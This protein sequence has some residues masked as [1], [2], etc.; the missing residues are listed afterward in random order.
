VQFESDGQLTLSKT[1]EAATELKCLAR[2]RE[3]GAREAQQHTHYVEGWRKTVGAANG[4]ER[5]RIEVWFGPV[6]ALAAD[7]NYREILSASELLA[8]DQIKSPPLR[9]RK[10]AGR[11]LLRTALSHV[12]H[13]R[14]TPREWRIHPDAKGRPVIAKSMPRINFS[15]SYA[16]AVAV[17]A[18]SQKLPVGI[19]VETV[20]DTAEDMIAAF[21]C[22]CEQGLLDTGPASQNSREF[23]RLWT[24]KEAYT[25]LV[26][27]GHGIEFDSIGFNLDSLHLLHG[28]SAQVKD[29]KVHFETMWV[30]SGRALNHVAIAIDFSSSARASADLQ[31]MSIASTDESAPAIHVPNVNILAPA[32]LQ[33]ADRR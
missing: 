11:M 3:N 25:K 29:R 20:E 5:D 4:P 6:Q 30:T 2:T 13:G 28:T 27:L 7:S 26:G 9:N 19:D 24:L 17:V 22:S 23:V 8:L 10:L 1:D 21:C 12:V 15:I 18:A 31:V 33:G 16:D 32:R 14:I